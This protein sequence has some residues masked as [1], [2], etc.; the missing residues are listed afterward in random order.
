MKCDQIWAKVIQAVSIHGIWNCVFYLL[1]GQVSTNNWRRYIW[2]ISSG[3][4][5]NING[6]FY[7]VE[8]SQ[9]HHIICHTNMYPYLYGSTS[10][11]WSITIISMRPAPGSVT[12]IGVLVVIALNAFWSSRYWLSSIE[13][14][15]RGRKGIRLNIYRSYIF[16]FPVPI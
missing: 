10:D 14:Y 5:C 16:A 6:M 3:G 13:L 7:S 1:L 8:M 9:Q 15:S 11:V 4:T 12:K 2:N